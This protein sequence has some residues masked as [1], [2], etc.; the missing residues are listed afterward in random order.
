MRKT[1]ACGL[2]LFKYN[3]FAEP[4]GAGSRPPRVAGIPSNFRHCF[5]SKWSQAG[6]R[7]LDDNDLE[8]LFGRAQGRMMRYTA[9]GMNPREAAMRAG[10]ELAQEH[11]ASAAAARQIALQNLQKRVE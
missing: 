2:L 4:C 5:E 3:H 9:S 11:L 7:Q 1:F 8:R 6:G 10:E